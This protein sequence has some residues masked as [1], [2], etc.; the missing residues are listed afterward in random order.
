MVEK[1]KLEFYVEDP[2]TGIINHTLL[3]LPF[4]HQFYGSI[5]KLRG[6]HDHVISGFKTAFYRVFHGRTDH[7]TGVHPTHII[8]VGDKESVKLPFFLQNFREQPTICGAGY[9]VDGLIR[10][11]KGG[12]SGFHGLLEGF[13]EQ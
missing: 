2:T 13:E 9:A 10:C 4:L 11:H 3:H 7:L 1:P 5:N 12:T 6:T 8:P